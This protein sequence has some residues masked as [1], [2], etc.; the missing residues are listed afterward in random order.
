MAKL[1]FDEIPEE[2]PLVKL[3]LGSGTGVNSPEGFIR[4]DKI[5]HV[6]VDIVA[7]LTFKWPW[8]SNSVDEAQANYLIHCLTAGQRVHFVNELWRVLKPGAKCVILTPHWCSSRAYG[9]P[10]AQWPPVS[11]AWYPWTNKAWRAA[12]PMVDMTGMKCNFDHTAGYSLH[13]QL[14][15]RNQEYQIQ[16]I[17]FWKEAAQDLVVTLTKLE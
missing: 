1:K 17:S 16:A 7:D 14:Q 9:D 15:S 12:Q 8:K 10:Q 4:V 3:D 5:K 11:E 6:N 13:P 2:K